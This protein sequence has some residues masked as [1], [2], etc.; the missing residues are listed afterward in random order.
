MCTGIFLKT[1]ENEYIFSRTLEFGI[2][3]NWYQICN[4]NFIGTIGI[5]PNMDTGY[6]TDGVN[7]EGLLV[8]TF[9]YPHYNQEYSKSKDNNKLNLY[10]GN[11]NKYLLENCNN[12]E[13][14]IKKIK[15]LNILETRLGGDLFS[16]HWAICDKSGRFL[17]LEVKDREL[18]YY[19]NKVNVITNSPT[20]PEHL[21]NLKNYRH[22]SKY[23]NPNSMSQGT[24]ALGLPGDSSSESRFVRA[25]FYRKNM[26]LPNSTKE[27]MNSLLRV[28]HDFDIPE[29]SVV[30][31]KSNEI[32]V[33][34]YTVVYSINKF[35]MKYA[36]YGNVMGKN[37]MWQQSKMPVVLC[38]KFINNIIPFILIGLSL[39][40]YYI[41]FQKR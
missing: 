37:K 27:G 29:G 3:F 4:N 11:L 26:P 23:S 25:N 32:E 1:R 31:K 7:K 8:A 19:E 13:E 6:L 17:V 39:S 20:F 16:L 35:K 24:G 21:K 34:Q 36:N 10:T 30:D 18:I 33:T 15:N 2:P 38:K 12:I 41:I 22:L 14:V 5:L 28:M 9:F 40:S